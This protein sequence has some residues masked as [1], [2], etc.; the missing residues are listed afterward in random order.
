MKMIVDSG[1]PLSLVSTNWLNE[2][3]KE[4]YVRSED[5]TWMDCMK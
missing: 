4:A 1:A 3:M 2:Y 5:L